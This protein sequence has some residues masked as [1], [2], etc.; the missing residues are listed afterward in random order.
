MH[1]IITA[2]TA[3]ALGLL[4]LALSVD[5]INRRMA[6]RAPFG[7]AGDRGLSAAIRGHGNLTEYLPIGLALIALLE[8]NGAQP[9]ALSIVAALFV[10]VRV[11]HAFGLRGSHDKLTAGR[12]VGIIG[13]LLILATMVGWLGA[14]IARPYLGF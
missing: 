8:A 14:T 6:L 10:L 2:A 4:L 12:S 5:I 13:T 9:L 11:A 7:D 3:T 1:L